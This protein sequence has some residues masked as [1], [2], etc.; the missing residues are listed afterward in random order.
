MIFVGI[1]FT[2][3]EHSHFRESNISWSETMNNRNKVS[4]KVSEL[5]QE[6]LGN[7]SE[8]Y[9]ENIT[10]QVCLA[11][12]ENNAWRNRYRRLVE[13]HSKLSV[14][15]QIGRSTR[16]ITGLRNLGLSAKATS[17]LIKTYTRLG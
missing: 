10:D 13:S 12:Q 11:I 4:I 2:E 5:V 8:P 1:V 14:N 7:I 15:S 3:I 6:V 9:P 17:S 16:Q